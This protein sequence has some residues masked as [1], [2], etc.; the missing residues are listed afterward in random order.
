[1]RKVFRLFDPPLGSPSG[2]GLHTEVAQEELLRVAKILRYLE[3]NDI[4]VRRANL[5]T[6]PRAFLDNP[7]LLDKLTEEGDGVLPA[8]YDEEEL[9]L[10][11]RYPTNEEVAEWYDLPLLKKRLPDLTEEDYEMLEEEARLWGSCGS[12]SCAGCS[13][14]G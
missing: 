11:G 3:K 4:D 8:L 2:I 7:E 10:S 13:G 1:M 6:K 5:T 12:G 14:C 9:L